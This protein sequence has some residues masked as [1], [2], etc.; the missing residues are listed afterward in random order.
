MHIFTASET[1]APRYKLLGGLFS[2]VIEGP[3]EKVIE[4]CRL[5]G[6]HVLPVHA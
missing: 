4:V 5:Q 6:R 1:L 2:E 3:P